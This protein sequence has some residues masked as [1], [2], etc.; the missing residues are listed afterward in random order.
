MLDIFECDL[1]P[2]P[3]VC[4]QINAYPTFC[5]PGD[6]TCRAHIHNVQV[7]YADGTIED[8]CLRGL[9]ILPAGGTS[10]ALLDHIETGRVTE[11]SG[12]KAQGG[13]RPV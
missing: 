3:V 11:R 8:I 13:E 9:Y 12:S 7:G 10:A 4:S 1:D 5:C 6:D 2:S